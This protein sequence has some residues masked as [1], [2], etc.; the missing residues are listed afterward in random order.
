MKLYQVH[1]F[2]QSRV[3]GLAEW[4]AKRPAERRNEA[5]KKPYLYTLGE[6]QEQVRVYTDAGMGKHIRIV[7]N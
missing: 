4:R 6:A 3:T 2:V 1:V 5:P 7:E